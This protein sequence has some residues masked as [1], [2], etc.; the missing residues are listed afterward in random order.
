M[1]NLY[2]SIIVIVL[3]NL[4][5][6]FLTFYMLFASVCSIAQHVR[7]GEEFLMLKIFTNLA[8]VLSLAVL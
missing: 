7:S 2:F 1:L 8:F 5:F 6:L 3:M 4:M